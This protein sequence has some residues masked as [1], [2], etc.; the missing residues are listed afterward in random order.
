MGRKKSALP[1]HARAGIK[2][3]PQRHCWLIDKKWKGRR[4]NFSTETDDRD[5][6]E[7]VLDAKLSLLRKAVRDGERPLYRLYEGAERYLKERQGK[8][9]FDNI[10]RSTLR[11]IQYTSPHLPYGS[12]GDTPL[13]DIHDGLL[14]PYIEWR[15]TE[16]IKTRKWDDEKRT[17]VTVWRPLKNSTINRDLE[18]LRTILVA[19][20]RRWRCSLTGKSWIDAAPLITM[21]ETMPSSGALRPEH[22]AE[23]YPLSWA[24]QDTLF[25]LLSPRL[26]AMCLFNVNTG[27]REQEVCRLRWD[28]EHDVPELNTTVFVI[29]RGYVKN[30]EARLVVLNRIARSIIQQQRELWCGKSDYV[31]PHPKTLKPF[32]KLF[33]SSWKQSWEA[34]GLPMGPWVTEGVHN[35]KHTCGRRLRAAGVQPETRKVCLGH[36]NGDIT[37]HYSA[38]EVKELID[39][40]ETLCQRRE[41]IVLRPR[42]YAIK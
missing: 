12:L 7:E 36:R 27:T 35:L 17:M 41:G 26:Q 29:P 21:L 40:F 5:E 9:T 19:A 11:L 33:T 15:R 34:A 14:E 18:A 6:A 42:M 8:A 32:K 23:A 37:T 3:C 24:E 2:W 38:A 22:S 10:R 30:G 25:P 1:Q 13:Q 16:G 20:A 31:F 28:W 4:L 39:A